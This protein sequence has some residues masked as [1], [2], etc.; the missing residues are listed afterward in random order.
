M[1]LVIWYIYSF[2]NSETYEKYNNDRRLDQVLSL[3]LSDEWTSVCNEKRSK[4][5]CVTFVVHSIIYSEFLFSYII[6]FSRFAHEIEFFFGLI[7]L[8][9]IGLMN[10]QLNWPYNADILFLH[11]IFFGSFLCSQL[12]WFPFDYHLLYS[13]VMI[14]I[15]CDRYACWTTISLSISNIFVVFFFFLLSTYLKRECDRILYN[16][17][18]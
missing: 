13:T 1:I 2:I 11:A 17:Y 6:F 18:H 4:E 12:F 5:N 8:F 10:I 7:L 15:F 14:W 16:S 9:V 3:Y